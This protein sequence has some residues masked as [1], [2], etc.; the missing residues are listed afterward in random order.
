MLVLFFNK[1]CYWFYAFLRYVYFHEY[2]SR[3]Q[4]QTFTQLNTNYLEDFIY[5]SCKH[6]KVK[7]TKSSKRFP[8]N[9]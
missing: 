5:A 8:A 7:K 2:L 3:R 1:N 6:I 4:I 9:R